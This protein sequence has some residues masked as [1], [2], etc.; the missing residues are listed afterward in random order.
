MKEG[1]TDHPA[2]RR[3]VMSPGINHTAATRAASGLMTAALLA[4]VLSAAT[5]GALAQE[6]RSWTLRDSLPSGSVDDAGILRR[7]SLGIDLLVSNGG[8]GFGTFYRREFSGDLSA[9]IDFS[10]SEAKD[11]DEV[12]YFNFYGQSFTLGKINRFLILPLMVGV[13]KRLFEHDILDNF[14]P[15]VNAAV[16][17]TMIYVFPEREEYFT[18]IGKGRPRYTAGGYLGAGAYFGSE[19]SNLLGLNLR[20]YFIPY[21]AGIEGLRGVPKKQFGGFFI[22]INFGSA[23]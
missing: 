9:F 21:P 23:W 1:A 8:F 6:R 17:P 7:H 2:P 14:R 18:A 11:D 4:I 15:Y 16:G 19:R 3:T 12:Q 13:Q 20:Y 10:I 22:T 5:P